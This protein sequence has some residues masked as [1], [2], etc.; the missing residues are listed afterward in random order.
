MCIVKSLHI[1]LQMIAATSKC[2]QRLLLTSDSSKN[3]RSGSQTESMQVNTEQ[4]IEPKR[5]AQPRQFETV[6]SKLFFITAH[7][8]RPTPFVDDL[9]PVHLEKW[10]FLFFFLIIILDT[11]WT[12]FTIAWTPDVEFAWIT[13]KDSLPVSEPFS[14]SC[15][16]SVSN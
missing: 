2:D 11:P 12:A 1:V 4:S 13:R 15:K 5:P 9:H 14:P 6:I 7:E 8:F 10:R 16:A 3:S